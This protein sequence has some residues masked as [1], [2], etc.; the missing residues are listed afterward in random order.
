MNLEDISE[1][2]QKSLVSF[3]NDDR[4]ID[5]IYKEQYGEENY[6]L[7]K[8]E[9]RKQYRE[10]LDNT[11]FVP[12][13]TLESLELFLALN[14]KKYGEN[15]VQKKYPDE[16]KL[17][18][19]LNNKRK[20]IINQYTKLLIEEVKSVVKD[21]ELDE[22]KLSNTNFKLNIRLISDSL[23]LDGKS[24]LQ[25][26]K[27][28]KIDKIFNKYEAAVNGKIITE[29]TSYYKHKRDYSGDKYYTSAIEDIKSNQS[30][31]KQAVGKMEEKNCRYIYL[32]VMTYRNSK[33][34][35]IFAVHEVMHISKEK[36]SKG[37]YQSGL[38][39]RYLD[40]N[41]MGSSLYLTD[42]I[43][44]NLLQSIRWAI[45]K[46]KNHKKI[47]GQMYYTASVGDIEM[48]EAIHHWQARKVAD[49]IIKD[50]LD[51]KLHI[52]YCQ[53]IPGQTKVIYERADSVTKRF[54]NNFEADI[55]KINCGEESVK[56]FKKKVG[57]ANYGL[58][59]T[60]Y[61]VVDGNMIDKRIVRGAATQSSKLHSSAPL[62]LD[63]YSELG[64][65][66]IQRMK[67]NADIYT[68][69][70][71]NSQKHSDAKGSAEKEEFDER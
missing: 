49:S 45:F 48:E 32:P 28:K 50:G 41:K 65:E 51:H 43:R 60:L 14:Q 59:S 39:T 68:K 64:E 16:L 15:Y 10:I 58:L 54:M 20:N 42:S 25:R 17:C 22:K 37:K 55:H 8:D 21:L 30:F 71:N 52:P 18:V 33:D 1:E 19:K 24:L 11:V 23:N 62:R 6:N 13:I 3:Y 12:Y 7:H 47:D 4:I 56:E 66:V 34:Y 38:L 53:N 2:Y 29:T 61:Q 31:V 9:Y 63:E 5:H 70:K 26:L 57:H 44:N 46:L 40:S 69:R 27:K 67:K 35:L 36:I